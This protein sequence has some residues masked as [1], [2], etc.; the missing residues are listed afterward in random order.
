MRLLRALGRRAWARDR[1]VLLCVI[2]K[3]STR[4]KTGIKCRWIRTAHPTTDKAGPEKFA[5]EIRCWARNRI[6]LQKRVKFGHKLEEIAKREKASIQCP[7]RP[8]NGF[9]RRQVNIPITAEECYSLGYGLLPKIMSLV[10]TF[11][12]RLRDAIQEAKAIINC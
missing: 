4:A 8:I 7:G 2:F 12:G 1:W 10:N 6:P 11:D 3:I 9:F 5:A